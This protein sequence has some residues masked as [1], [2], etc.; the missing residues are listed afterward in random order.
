M[1]RLFFISPLCEYSFF[2]WLDYS[3][4]SGCEKWQH[5]VFADRFTLLP[6]HDHK[7]R[8][9]D[10][11]HDVPHRQLGGAA[12]QLVLVVDVGDWRKYPRPARLPLGRELLPADVLA[13]G[14]DEG[15]LVKPLVRQEADGD[16]LL[17]VEASEGVVEDEDVEAAVAAHVLVAAGAPVLPLSDLVAGA[18]LPHLIRVVEAFRVAA[19]ALESKVAL[20]T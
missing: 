11:A 13:R 20:V 7:G 3:P 1:S 14:A 19:V 4:F 8:R 5:D 9:E 12:I 2:S 16:L 15:S 10:H 18:L 17:R 6:H